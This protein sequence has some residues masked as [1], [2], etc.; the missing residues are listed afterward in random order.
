M[1]YSGGV[2]PWWLGVSLTVAGVAYVIDTAARTML[3]GYKP[4][5][6]RVPG[7]GGHPVGGR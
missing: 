1:M 2:G 3:A 5:G 4:V 7:H 6:G